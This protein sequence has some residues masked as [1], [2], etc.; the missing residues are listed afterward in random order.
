[1]ITSDL[2]HLLSIKII[3]MS[4][5]RTQPRPSYTYA[6]L[7]V[8]RPKLMQEKLFGPTMSGMRLDRPGGYGFMGISQYVIENPITIMRGLTL[9]I[10]TCT[11]FTMTTMPSLVVKE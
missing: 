2:S 7:F 10:N 4:L 6:F 9:G 5:D 8:H 11:C 1:M 3:S